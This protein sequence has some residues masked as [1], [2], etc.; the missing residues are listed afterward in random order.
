MLG[1][2]SNIYWS[3][4]RFARTGYFFFQGFQHD[5]GFGQ[6]RKFIRGKRS[7]Y[8]AQ[9]PTVPLKNIGSPL[10]SMCFYSLFD[11]IS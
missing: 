7:N 1:N 4:D 6:F 8:A 3:T 5:E 11:Q 9:W 10:I 2:N